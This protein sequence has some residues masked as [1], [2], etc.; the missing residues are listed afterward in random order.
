[1]IG[2]SAREF[3]L[4]LFSPPSVYRTGNL[5]ENLKMEEEVSWDELRIEIFLIRKWDEFDE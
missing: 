5:T 1:M 4:P 2:D 3:F